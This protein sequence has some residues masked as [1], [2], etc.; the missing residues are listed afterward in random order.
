MLIR[1]LI[2]YQNKA[3]CQ[4]ACNPTGTDNP[5]AAQ[6]THM[7]SVSRLWM[8]C[9]CVYSFFQRWDID[10]RVLYEPV[11]FKM[12]LLLPDT[13]QMSIGFGD[14]INVS[15][16][17]RI[18]VSKDA[19]PVLDF[20]ISSCVCVAIRPQSPQVRGREPEVFLIL[21]FSLPVLARYPCD[22]QTAPSVS[23]PAAVV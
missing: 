13:E 3:H 18:N 6:E 1:F 23:V 20:R 5:R 22:R 11:I 10:T 19:I 12:A 16:P 17:A 15:A 7:T 8:A 2:W 9:A 14:A 21:C 4:S